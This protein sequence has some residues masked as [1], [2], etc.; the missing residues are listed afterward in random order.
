MVGRPR[1]ARASANDSPPTPGAVGRSD[2]RPA[3]MFT[4]DPSDG[5]G[6]DLDRAGDRVARDMAVSQQVEAIAAARLTGLQQL[7]AA[8]DQA[9]NA[10]AVM[11]LQTRLTAE[12]AMITNDQIRLQGLAMTQDAEAR[13]ATQREKERAKVARTSRMK[14]YQE[15][16]R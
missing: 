2:R 3:A 8:L 4:P 11:D 9:P 6:V 7:N 10:R 14:V 15:T 12:Q 5:A 1:D 13:L 16:F